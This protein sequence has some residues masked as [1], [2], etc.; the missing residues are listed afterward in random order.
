MCWIIGNLLLLTPLKS[1]S[2][3]AQRPV[4]IDPL[5]LRK[6][7]PLSLPTC[8]LWMLHLPSGHVRELLGTSR[9]SWPTVEL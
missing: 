6:Y 3:T 5:F 4:V 9:Q 7:E 8:F 2:V 1:A